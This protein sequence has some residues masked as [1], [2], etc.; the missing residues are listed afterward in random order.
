MGFLLKKIKAF[1]GK[2][3]TQMLKTKSFSVHFTPRLSTMTTAGRCWN[4]LLLPTLFAPPC[5]HYFLASPL[6]V[7]V[8]QCILCNLLGVLV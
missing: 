3:Y 2:C 6:K 1:S 4:N 7:W 5:C 8:R